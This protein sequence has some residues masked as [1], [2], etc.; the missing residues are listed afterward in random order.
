MHL[1]Y[2]T[3][4]CDNVIWFQG[5]LAHH[6]YIHVMIDEVFSSNSLN[7]RHSPQQLLR[8]YQQMKFLLEV[9]VRQTVTVP[10]LGE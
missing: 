10:F 6:M 1:E 9:Y 4:W 3:A 5:G 7:I 2:I 8:G